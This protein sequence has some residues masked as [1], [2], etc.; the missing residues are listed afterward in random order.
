M[1]LPYCKNVFN[2]PDISVKLQAI[3]K[4]K[5]LSYR[6]AFCTLI[7]V[8]MSFWGGGEGGG[9]KEKLNNLPICGAIKNPVVEKYEKIFRL[10]NQHSFSHQINEHFIF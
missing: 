8:E 4:N 7:F 1:I 3:K 10:I 2:P 9:K 5:K 6:R